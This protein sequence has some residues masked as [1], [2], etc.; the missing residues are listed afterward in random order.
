MATNC[1][2][3]YFPRFSPSRRT[4]LARTSDCATRKPTLFCMASATKSAPSCSAMPGKSS[5]DTST[6]VVSG[7]L[8]QDF[9]RLG[10]LLL[11]LPLPAQRLIEDLL[12]VGDIEQ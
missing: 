5:G 8:Q 10:L 11:L 2:V 3:G 6:E 1:S 12:C 4:S 9:L 7:V